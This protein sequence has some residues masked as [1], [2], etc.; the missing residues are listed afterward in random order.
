MAG[1]KKFRNA[2]QACVLLRKSFRNGVLARSVT[3]I[4]LVLCDLQGKDRDIKDLQ[5]IS[6]T[7][8]IYMVPSPKNMIHV[9]NEPL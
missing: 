8:Y 1:K 5:N 4:P 2:V 7:A 6:N 9:S 3:K